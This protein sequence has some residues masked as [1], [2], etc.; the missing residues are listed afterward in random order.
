[1]VVTSNQS[2]IISIISIIGIIGLIGGKHIDFMDERVGTI[3]LRFRVF[4]H[5]SGLILGLILGLKFCIC[6][7]WFDSGWIPVSE[8]HQNISW[9]FPGIL[10]EL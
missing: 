5:D 4:Y 6:D 3:S 8:L 2:C 10:L 9:N 1:V 7:S